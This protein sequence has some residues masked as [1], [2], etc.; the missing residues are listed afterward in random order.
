[1]RKI[2]FAF[3]AIPLIA[4]TQAPS[5][6][7]KIGERNAAPEQLFA[8]I[9]EGSS[10]AELERMAAAAAAHP[11]G[12]LLN[13]VRVGGPEGARAYIARLRCADGSVARVGP[14]AGGGIG[15]YGSV[16]ERYSLDC[17]AAAPG[18]VDL[19]LDVYHEGHQ[20]SR[21]PAGL[22]LGAR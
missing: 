20:E 16:T 3:M 11:L 10:D 4:A 12:T 9:G 14:R 15:A 2:L 8:G 22:R 6:A 13:P 17:G 19:V 7:G 5:P 21:A 18:R 1:M